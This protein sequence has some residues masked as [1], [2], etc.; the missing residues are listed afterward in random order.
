MKISAAANATAAPSST[1]IPVILPSLAALPSRTA[2]RSVD[3]RAALLADGLVSRE[4]ATCRARLARSACACATT[5]CLYANSD[6]ITAAGILDRNPPNGGSGAVAGRSA[7]TLEEWTA[8]SVCTLTGTLQ[9]GFE[10]TRV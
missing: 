3:T 4:P 5:S 1:T 7:V 10:H 2:H 6:V 9:R 8:S